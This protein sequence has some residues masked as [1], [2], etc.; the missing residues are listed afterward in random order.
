MQPGK[1]PA[2]ADDNA[3][4]RTTQAR[5]QRAGV[6][7][8]SQPSAQQEH[9]VAAGKASGEK[10]KA[11]AM[12]EEESKRKKA[13]HKREVPAQKAA[14]KAAAAAAA[15][16]TAR[17]KE[18]K[19]ARAA[20]AASERR[21]AAMVPSLEEFN[22]WLAP[23]GERVDEEEYEYAF[24]RWA[25]V[26]HLDPE[27]CEEIEFLELF[28]VWRDSDDYKSYLRNLEANEMDEDA[29]EPPPP[30]QQRAGSL[31]KCV[32]CRRNPC[33]CLD[34]RGDPDD[35]PWAAEDFGYL[36]PSPPRSPQDWT[37]SF[38]W[39]E[40]LDLEYARAAGELGWWNTNWGDAAQ[41]R[42]HSEWEQQAEERRVRKERERAAG[43]PPYREQPRYGPLGDAAGNELFRQ[44]RAAWYETFTGRSIAGSTLQEQNE[45]CD[46]IARRFRTYTDGRSASGSGAGL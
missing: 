27:D 29:R 36:T 16:G 24:Q 2:A 31:P 12:S 40:F 35:N 45:L 8:Q 11:N 21:R 3:T 19:T 30:I 34:D 46:A 43:Q 28:F 13:A 39:D 14:E 44:E 23:H 41:P 20:A 7:R 33:A 5:R 37:P 18:A 1:E 26:G 17:D 25:H 9:Q 22:R 15:R 42:M 38:T 4:Q 6:M 10:R 32:E